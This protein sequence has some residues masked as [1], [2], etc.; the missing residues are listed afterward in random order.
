MSTPLTEG[1]QGFGPGRVG[2]RLPG[3]I[4]VGAPGAAAAD[5]VAG[6]AGAWRSWCWP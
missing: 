1:R 2:L 6:G 3:S 4:R 5:V